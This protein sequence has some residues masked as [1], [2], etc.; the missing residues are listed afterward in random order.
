LHGSP[1][2]HRLS[3]S[4]SAVAF[5]TFPSSAPIISA[6]RARAFFLVSNSTRT[7]FISV[8]LSDFILNP[9]QHLEYRLAM[10]VASDPFLFAVTGAEQFGF[11][12]RVHDDASL[13]PTASKQIP[14]F[15]PILI[16]PHG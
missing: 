4:A 14:I 10:D 6:W 8:S 9:H 15:K 2:A 5:E 3:L 13:F 16:E 7:N 12:G 1:S 11:D